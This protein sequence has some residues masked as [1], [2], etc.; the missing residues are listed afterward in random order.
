V[1]YECFGEKSTLLEENTVY[2]RDHDHAAGIYAELPGL[3]PLD[4]ILTVLFP[5]N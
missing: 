1:W 5:D 4:P 3:G 2:S